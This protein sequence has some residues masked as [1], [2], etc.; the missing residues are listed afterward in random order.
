[1]HYYFLTN[2]FQQ[3]GPL[4]RRLLKTVS[5]SVLSATLSFTLGGCSTTLESFDCKAGK[6]VGCKS[7]SEVNHMV[8]QGVLGSLEERDAVSR[9]M[10]STLPLENVPL[11]HLIITAGSPGIETLRDETAGVETLFKQTEVPLSDAM[12]VHRIQEEHLRVWIAPFQDEHGN[13]HEGSVIHTVLKP[14][15]WQL[16]TSP[17]RVSDPRV[18]DP[19]V[20]DSKDSSPRD[21]DPRDSD[22]TDLDVREAD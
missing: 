19:S 18:N 15:Y 13:L 21:T 11:S 20:T 3:N 5:A 2:R 12:A 7:I 16:K 9:S 6:G 8:D 14:G 1:M 4:H 10:Q 17:Q 22:S